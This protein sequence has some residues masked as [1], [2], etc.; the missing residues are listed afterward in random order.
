[1]KIRIPF[2]KRPASKN[3]YETN[4][5]L[6]SLLSSLVRGHLVYAT[7]CHCAAPRV[8]QGSALLT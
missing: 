7:R 4:T 1:M 6:L 5:E 8:I 2:G 3:M